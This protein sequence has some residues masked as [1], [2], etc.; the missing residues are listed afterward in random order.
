MIYPI[1]VFLVE[2][3]EHYSRTIPARDRVGRTL[4]RVLEIFALFSHKKT[5]LL[6]YSII[7]FHASC[8]TFNMGSENCSL[9]KKY[10]QNTVKRWLSFVILPPWHYS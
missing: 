5:V 8:H 4:L 10:S 3:I 7:N 2:R 1:L 9:V 6:N